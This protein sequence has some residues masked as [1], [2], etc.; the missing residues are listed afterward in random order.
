M[1]DRRQIALPCIPQPELPEDEAALRQLAGTP[2]NIFR[3][4]HSEYHFTVDAAALP[5]NA[6]LERHWTPEDDGQSQDWEPERVW[7]NPPYDDIAPWVKK[8]KTALFAALLLPVR[9]DRAWFQRCGAEIHFFVGRM[10]FEAPPGVKYTSNPDCNMLLL[11]GQGTVPGRVR[12][13]C[14]QTGLLLPDGFEAAWERR[15][16]G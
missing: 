14:S 2:R 7:N 9:T 16:A 15:A 10:A 12:F 3:Q 5:F 13:R 11:F 8:A 1:S 4:L 6:K